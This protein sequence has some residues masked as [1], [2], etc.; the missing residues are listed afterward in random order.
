MKFIIN[1]EHAKLD[2]SALKKH[3]CVAPYQTFQIFV[4]GK[5]EVCCPTWMSKPIGNFFT[6]T[7]EEVFN[8]PVLKHI[9][10]DMKEG[11]Y[12]Y[13]NDTCPYLTKLLLSQPENGGS[14]T[15]G[16]A[17]TPL[18]TTH[19]LAK[20]L[21][22]I[23]YEVY[24]NFDRSCNLQCPSCRI[25]LEVFTKNKT[26]EEWDRLSILQKQA[27]DLV[28]LML[29]RPDAKMVSIN[30]TGSGDPFASETYW[31]YL[32][33]LNE[34]GHLPRY[35]KLRI[36]LQTNG[37][38]MTPEKMNKIKNLWKRLDIVSVSVDSTTQETYSKVR[39]GGKIE[40]VLNNL[41]W[42]DENVSSGN[43]ST[44]W[45][46]I[47]H[48]TSWNVNFI[49]QAENYKEMADFAKYHTQHKSVKKIWFNLI[50]D[51]G[52]LDTSYGFGTF[53][54]KAIWKEAHPEH[55]D[56]LNVLKDPIFKHPKLDVGTM[57]YFINKAQA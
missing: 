47:V 6:D 25:N 38:L 43:L 15:F 48:P 39:K 57:T 20:F 1:P 28:E 33:K 2:Q 24:F 26:P 50:A 51:W 49:V 42:L 23:E 19:Q 8:S 36:R 7:A 44:I 30:I 55:Q 37:L 21:K 10:E 32:L 56:F 4:D 5:V 52:H 11:K 34:V 35:E 14:Q 22:L 12:S 13:C 27:E 18:Y 54:K 3:T 45:D 46:G 31:N 29:D 53:N 40:N 17:W 9:K 41:K 16:I